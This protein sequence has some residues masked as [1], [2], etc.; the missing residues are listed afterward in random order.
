LAVLLQCEHRIYVK[1]ASCQYAI[2]VFMARVFK[3]SGMDT[4]QT[5]L[6]ARSKEPSARLLSCRA[7]SY[8]RKK[9]SQQPMP[10]R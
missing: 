5:P 10:D 6:H 3:A 2:L 4:I 9:F 8:G 1:I 7:D